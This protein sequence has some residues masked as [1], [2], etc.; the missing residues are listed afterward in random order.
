MGKAFFFIDPNMP[1]D[2]YSYD[3]IL[4]GP[5]VLF[6]QMAVIGSKAISTGDLVYFDKFQA[7]PPATHQSSPN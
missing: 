2:G 5:C 1:M 3:N 7:R 4:P 6:D